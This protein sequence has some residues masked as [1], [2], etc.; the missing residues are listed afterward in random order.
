MGVLTKAEKKTLTNLAFK[1][2]CRI[3]KKSRAADDDDYD[4]SQERELLQNAVGVIQRHLKKI[5]LKDFYAIQE[6]KNKQK[7][8]K[9]AKAKAAK[10][11]K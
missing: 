2:S 7:E 1:V 8:T 9:K 4:S 6:K 3:D 11:V 10:A 5:T